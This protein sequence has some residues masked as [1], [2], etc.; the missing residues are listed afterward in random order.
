MINN[1]KNCD[2]SPKRYV[3]NC[4]LIVE[5]NVKNCD[6]RIEKYKNLGGYIDE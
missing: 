6:Y 1:V 5:N 2:F 3:K 4:K